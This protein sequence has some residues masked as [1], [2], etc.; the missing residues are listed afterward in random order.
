MT[1]FKIDFYF[2]LYKDRAINTASFFRDYLK[3]KYAEKDEI[4]INKVFLKINKYQIEKYG[5][6][7][8]CD[9]GYSLERK[10][11]YEN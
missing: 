4:L 3:F 5:S 7:L 6:N 10:K 2:N 1:N 8:T 11:T 9:G